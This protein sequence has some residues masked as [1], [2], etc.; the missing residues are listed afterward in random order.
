MP[1]PIILSLFI[2]ILFL[3]ACSQT[4]PE[5][6]L[7]SLT[8]RSSAKAYLKTR[9]QNIEGWEKLVDEIETGI[10]AGDKQWLA[11]AIKL[12]QV[13]DA[14]SSLALNYSLSRNLP[15]QADLVLSALS[16]GFDLNDICT[17]PFIET[18]DKIVDEFL[19]QSISALEKSKM[20]T[21]EPCRKLLLPWA[22]SS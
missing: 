1:R 18:P 22:K 11:V 12:H 2:S 21:A 4:K 9:T 17:I 16:Q 19:E 13:S 7:Q 14:S 20:P 6:I 10:R 8:D 5:K 15:Y 3:T